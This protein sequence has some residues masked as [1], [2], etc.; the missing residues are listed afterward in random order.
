MTDENRT[1]LIALVAASTKLEAAAQLAKEAASDV[2]S[3]SLLPLEYVQ[4]IGD[5]IRACVRRID[6]YVRRVTSAIELI[7]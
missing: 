1:R 4:D 6:D 7:P 3:T 5:D 2:A